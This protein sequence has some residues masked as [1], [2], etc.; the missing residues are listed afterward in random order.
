M[1]QSAIAYAKICNAVYNGD[2]RDDVRGRAGRLRRHGPAREQQPAERHG[3]SV[4]PIAF[5]VAAKKAGMKHVRRLR[6][7]PVLRRADRDA[8]DEAAGDEERRGADRDHARRTS[9]C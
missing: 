9:T 6:A 8:D 2:P 5:L 3:P 4:S 7:Q 1:I